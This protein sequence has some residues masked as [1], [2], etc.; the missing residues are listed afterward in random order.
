MARFENE[1][2]RAIRTAQENGRELAA[3]SATVTENGG[4]RRIAIVFAVTQRGA[5]SLAACLGGVVRVGPAHVRDLQGAIAR[6]L[7]ARPESV[8]A[9]HAAPAPS[10]RERA[11]LYLKG[12]AERPSDVAVNAVLGRVVV[13][14]AAGEPRKAV[15]VGVPR[16]ALEPCVGE[17]TLTGGRRAA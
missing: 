6:I 12:V 15:N 1:Q 17:Y 7:A 3:W 9:V 16:A 2:A 10:E 4:G 13:R 11:R 14:R 5:T 8:A